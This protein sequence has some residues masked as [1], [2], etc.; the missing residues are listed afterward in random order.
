MRSKENF[1][2]KEAVETK[3]GANPVVAIM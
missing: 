2:K 3:K 1:G